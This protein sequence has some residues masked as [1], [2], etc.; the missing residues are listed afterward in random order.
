MLRGLSVTFASIALAAAHLAAASTFEIAPIRVELGG[1][2]HIAVLTLTNVEDAPVVVEMHVEDWSQTD[3]VDRLQDTKDLLGTPPVM[4]IA[5]HAQQIV[6]VALMRAPDPTRELSYRVILQEVPRA[7]PKNFEGLRVALRLSVPIFVAPAHGKAQ[8][9][10][11][12]RGKWL[13]DGKLRL[14]ATNDGTGHV[15]VTD[16]ALRIGAAEILRNV[17]AKYV[18]PGSTMSWTLTPPAGLDRQAVMHLAGHSDA[19]DLSSTVTF[20]GA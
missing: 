6:R 8:G 9:T 20:S 5:P 18:L 17:A 7:A 4:Q 2:R 14:S 11:A 19:G 1:A 3:G 13:P 15:E 12:W 16:F 10:L